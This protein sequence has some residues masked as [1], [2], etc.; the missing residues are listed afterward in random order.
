MTRLAKFFPVTKAVMDPLLESQERA[1]KQLV[2]IEQNSDKLRAA[3]TVRKVKKLW[4][5]RFGWGG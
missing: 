1:T 2:T 5:G 4:N 3:F